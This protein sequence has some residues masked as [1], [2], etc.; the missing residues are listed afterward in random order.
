M[1]CRWWFSREDGVSR[2]SVGGLPV[3]GG[4]DDAGLVRLVERRE[5]AQ[6]EH[7]LDDLARGELDVFVRRVSQDAE[8]ERVMVQIVA[9][10]NIAQDVAEHE[11]R[12]IAGRS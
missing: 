3:H 5:F 11:D 2:W 6:S 1:P 12:K 10:G 4:D 8:T 7:G 9:N